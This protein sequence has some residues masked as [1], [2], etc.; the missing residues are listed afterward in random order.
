MWPRGPPD[1]KEILKIARRTTDIIQV[2]VTPHVC[3]FGSA[4]AFLWADT[5]RVPNVR[6]HPLAHT[7]YI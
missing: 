7:Q 5:G 4:G 3:L 6:A 2:H 1:T